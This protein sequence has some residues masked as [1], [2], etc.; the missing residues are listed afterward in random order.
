MNYVG[1]LA[2]GY[3]IGSLPLGYII[4]AWHDI[5][6]SK[7][8]SGSSGSTNIMRALGIK[9]GLF[10]MAFDMFKGAGVVIIARMLGYDW[11]IAAAVLFAAAVGH[12]YPLFLWFRGGG[13]G[14]NTIVGG[15]ALIA[16]WQVFLVVLTVWLFLFVKHKLQKK[17]IISLVNLTVLVPGIPI[18]LGLSYL[19]WQWGLI[20]LGFS[21]FLC[22][23]HR[24]NI[25]RLLRGEEK[26]LRLHNSPP[27]PPLLP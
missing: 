8:G 23:T 9:W 26:P 5:E 13:K 21:I 7:V 20:G 25:K 14:V 4:A 3:I 6:I 27:S 17:L 24:D 19:S 1:V 16:S 15:M 22:W 12:A 18:G 2:V 10:I 11:M